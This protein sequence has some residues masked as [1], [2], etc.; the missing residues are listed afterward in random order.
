MP[1]GIEAYRNIMAFFDFLCHPENILQAVGGFAE[2]AEAQLVK[3]CKVAIQDILQDF[4]F[5][6]LTFQPEVAAVV[7]GV[8]VVSDAKHT[9]IRTF[10]GNIHIERV[11]MCVSNRHILT[12]LFNRKKIFCILQGDF[13]HFFF[14]KALYFGYLFGDQADKAR[15]VPPAPE[16]HGGH[17][18]AV[19]CD[20]DSVHRSIPDDIDGLFGVG[21]GNRPRKGQIVPP[22]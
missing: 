22:L 13:G 17:I 3:L 11:F 8:L 2:A 10:I 7:Y 6:R 20:H 19:G 5:R 4:L 21:K 15:I 18:G 14:G 12:A 16:G 9:A 1:V